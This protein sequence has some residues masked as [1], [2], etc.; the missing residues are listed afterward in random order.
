LEFSILF[1][2]EIIKQVVIADCIF[3]FAGHMVSAATS[4][5]DIAI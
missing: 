1:S 2:V 3:Y 5:S 4:H